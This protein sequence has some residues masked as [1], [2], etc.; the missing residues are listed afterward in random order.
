MDQTTVVSGAV[1]VPSTHK[2]V[3]VVDIPAEEVG[4]KVLVV[5]DPSMQIATAPFKQV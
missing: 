4:W 5:V 2:R 1:E 3:V